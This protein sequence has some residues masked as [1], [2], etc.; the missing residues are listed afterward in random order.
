M[1]ADRPPRSSP[2]WL[3]CCLPFSARPLLGWSPMKYRLEMVT[4]PIE[5][6]DGK[7]F[8]VDDVA[9]ARRLLQK[10]GV[11]VSE[12]QDFPWG[13][14]SHPDGNEWSVHEVPEAVRASSTRTSSR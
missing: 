5:H 3:K 1:N 12:V 4:V 13:R 11:N 2:T 10:R 9:A 6:V 14:F 8:N 7:A